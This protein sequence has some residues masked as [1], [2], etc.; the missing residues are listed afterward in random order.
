MES[1][2]GEC[3]DRYHG[4]VREMDELKIR[5]MLHGR[6]II[7]LGGLTYAVAPI[8]T[9][10]QVLVM[11][12]PHLIHVLNGHGDSGVTVW[13]VVVSG[14]S[15]AVVGMTR[16]RASV[17]AG[18]ALVVGVAG[19][20]TTI[21]FLIATIREAGQVAGLFGPWAALLGAIAMITGGTLARASHGGAYDGR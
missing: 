12:K 14:V 10:L 11:G 19:A 1:S 21:V 15:V 4:V 2:T 6:W 16:M 18:I 9:W 7:S 8:L 17:V 20:T 13:L 3:A 5:Q